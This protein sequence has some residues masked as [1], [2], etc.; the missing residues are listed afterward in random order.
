MKFKLLALALVLFSAMT[1]AQTAAELKNE[2]NEALRTKDYATALAKFEA[3]IASGEEGVSEDIKSV[4]NAANCAYKLKKYDLANK[5]FG[6]SITGDYKKDLSTYYQSM[7]LKKTGKEQESVDLLEK[8]IAD[9]PNSKYNKKFVKMV[10]TH[11]SKQA[12]EP[13][14]SGNQISAGAAASGDGMTYLAEMK[15]AFAKFELAKPLF[16]K[17]LTI[18]PANATAKAALANMV[19]EQKRYTEYKATLTKK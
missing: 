5:Y 8:A 3:Y 9:Y 14:N 11:Y 6:Q 10:A 2:G 15:K 7:I 1:F 19:D 17:V 13:Y 16:E 12:L 18:D 4:Y